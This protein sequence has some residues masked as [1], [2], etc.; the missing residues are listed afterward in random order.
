[1]VRGFRGL[2]AFTAVGFREGLTMGMKFG[3]VM[4]Y[5]FARVGMIAILASDV[6]ILGRAVMGVVKA[7]EFIGEVA[8]LQVFG[9]VSRVLGKAINLPGW[10]GSSFMR[11]LGVTLAHMAHSI[12]FVKG[13][14]QYGSLFIAEGANALG[15]LV[16]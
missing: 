15:Q 1:M 10:L 12:Y 14:I 5:I 2:A 8:S 16:P 3:V 13:F 4:P 6:P 7:I 11:D 9:G